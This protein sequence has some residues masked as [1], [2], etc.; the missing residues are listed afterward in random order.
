[1]E[2]VLRK[3]EL[4]RARLRAVRRAKV[5]A[6]NE[7]PRLTAGAAVS[8]SPLLAHETGRNLIRRSQPEKKTETS[9]AVFCLNK[10]K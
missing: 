7:P 6:R 8:Y 3:Q 9:Y 10:I 4:Q 5:Q 2:A 1:M